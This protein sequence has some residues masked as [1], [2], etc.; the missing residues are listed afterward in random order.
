M[1]DD[2]SDSPPPKQPNRMLAIALAIVAA[3][4]LGYAAFSHRWLVNGN[5]IEEFGFGLRDNYAC[6]SVESVRECV[7]ESNSHY[8]QVSKDQGGRAADLASSAF[9]PCG[10]ATFVEC[11][12]AMLGLAGAAGLAIAK[13][14]R[15]LPMSPS[16]LAMLALMAALITGCVFVA[17]KPGEAGYVGVGPSFWVFGAGAVLGIAGA[18][19]LAKVNRPDDIDLMDDAMNPDEF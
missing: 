8:V 16:T 3:G 17:Q 10:W 6:E 14:K 1:S 7:T 13:H 4:C 19:L 2:D 15:H 12:L 11:L 9:A 5:R 18:Q